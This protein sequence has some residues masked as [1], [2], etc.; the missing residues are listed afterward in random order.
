[1]LTTLTS[2]SFPRIKHIPFTF[3]G[4]D[5]QVDYV[6]TASRL[7]VKKQNPTFL[8]LFF[9]TCH[10]I[11]RNIAKKLSEYLPITP[12]QSRAFHELEIHTELPI[13]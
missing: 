13:V 2:T 6:L 3:L 9:K 11:T 4:V 10:L 1:M 8:F 12:Y 7:I 5:L